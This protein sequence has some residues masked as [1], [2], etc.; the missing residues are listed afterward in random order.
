MKASSQR[1]SN[2]DNTPENMETGEKREQN[3]VIIKRTSHRVTEN[4]IL[5]SSLI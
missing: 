3:D 4:N 5:V 2:L 1:T